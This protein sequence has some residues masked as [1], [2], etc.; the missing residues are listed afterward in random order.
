MSLTFI[1]PRNFVNGELVKEMKRIIPSK[2]DLP[3]KSEDILRMISWMLPRKEESEYKE[4][5]ERNLA[6]KL[7]SYIPTEPFE[8][9]KMLAELKKDPV[10]KLKKSN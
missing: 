2:N 8:E 4:I 7:V 9:I 3:S 6:Q 1:N 10:R 5:N